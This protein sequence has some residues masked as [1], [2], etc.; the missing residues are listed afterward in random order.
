MRVLLE[1]GA[2][3]EVPNINGESPLSVAKQ[4]GSHFRKITSTLQFFFFS[5]K[6]ISE[7]LTLKHIVCNIFAALESG[8][9]DAVRALVSQDASLVNRQNEVT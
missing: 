9:V 8:N 4:Y 1:G 6:T 5:L 2:D 7:M 3:V